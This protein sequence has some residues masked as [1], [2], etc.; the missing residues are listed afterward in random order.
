MIALEL[1]AR[2]LVVQLGSERYRL[3]DPLRIVELS[4]ERGDRGLRI[5]LVSRSV[6]LR[7]RVAAKPE[8]IGASSPPGQSPKG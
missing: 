6:F 4:G 2:E 1:D 5:E 8:M 3:R 7:F